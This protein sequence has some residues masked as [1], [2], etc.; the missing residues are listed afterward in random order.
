[1]E[2]NGGISLVGDLLLIRPTT[3]DHTRFFDCLKNQLI[4]QLKFIR[5]ILEKFGSPYK[6]VE[7][8]AQEG[9]IG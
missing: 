4:N 8:R 7:V 2:S 3:F 5:L 9:L 6:S 1:M